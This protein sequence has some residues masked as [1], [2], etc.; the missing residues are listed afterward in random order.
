MR[1]GKCALP[2]VPNGSEGTFSFHF[3]PSLEWANRFSKLL[4][5]G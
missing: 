3:L 5:F 4:V 1:S 2:G